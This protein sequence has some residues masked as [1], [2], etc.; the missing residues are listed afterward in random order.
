MMDGGPRASS[1]RVKCQ[2]ACGDIAVLHLDTKRETG[3]S[4][5]RRADDREGEGF[6][7]RVAA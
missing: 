1:L 4:L 3:R 7:M 2:S 6:L 5:R